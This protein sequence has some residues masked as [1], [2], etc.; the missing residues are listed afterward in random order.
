MK[1]R[2]LVASIAALVLLTACAQ[3]AGE[4]DYQTADGLAIYLGVLPAAMIQGHQ[5]HPEERMHGG[6]PGGRHAYHVV[7]AVFDEL[8]G[9]RIENAM[10]QARVVP[11]GLAAETRALEPMEIAGTVTY[12]N[13]FT[14]GGDDPYRIEISITRSGAGTPVVVDFSYR[15]G[16]L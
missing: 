4:V 9:E 7:A 5:T 14:M 1:R 3:R 8:T 16:P 11:R 6:V 12:G 15:H 13:Y 2:T 10:V